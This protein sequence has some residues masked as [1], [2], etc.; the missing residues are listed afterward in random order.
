MFYIFLSQLI[1]LRENKTNSI[2]YMV[3]KRFITLN[4]Y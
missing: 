4:I 1:E 2:L 3:T